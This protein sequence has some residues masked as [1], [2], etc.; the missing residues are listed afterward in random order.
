MDKNRG[1]AFAWLIILA[2]VGVISL[3]LF[4][5]QYTNAPS[6]NNI[7]TNNTNT[8]VGGSIFNVTSVMLDQPIKHTFIDNP[9][10]AA[11]IQNEKLVFTDKSTGEK[12]EFGLYDLLANKTI[13][14]YKSNTYEVRYSLRLLELKFDSENTNYYGLV[15]II[16]GADP[17]VNE[18]ATLF[19]INTQNWNVEK[20]ALPMKNY[21]R[22]IT[23]EALNTNMNIL[24]LEVASP[25]KQLYLYSFSYVNGKEKLLKVYDK[26]TFEKYLPGKYG[27]LSYL[28]PWFGDVESRTLNAKW[29]NNTSLSY[30]D[31]VT[32]EQI[33]VT[34]D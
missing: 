22:D 16:P 15:T 28:H 2:S 32:R 24:L 3:L 1:N 7:T 25:D 5:K 13:Q 19:K 23:P 18:A 14:T 4:A 30:Q 11:L 9:N 20:Y 29:I 27:F 34:I 33:T 12:K 31:F 17:P 8:S 21:I 6:V 26:E 10:G